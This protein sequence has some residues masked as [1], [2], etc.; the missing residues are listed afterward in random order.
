MD[1]GL[2]AEALRNRHQGNTEVRRDVFH[3]YRHMHVRYQ[4]FKA[5]SA[6]LRKNEF[7]GLTKPASLTK[8]VRT[9]PAGRAV[10]PF[11]NSHY[12]PIDWT[13]LENGDSAKVNFTRRRAIA[14]FAATSLKPSGLFRG[15]VG[16]D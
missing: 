14:L 2:V 4:S 12:K 3:S 6:A 7:N 16:C 13:I 8:A 15:T 5:S 10:R 9:T 1:I 11:A